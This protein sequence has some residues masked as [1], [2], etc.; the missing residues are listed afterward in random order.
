MGYGA[1]VHVASGIR[2]MGAIKPMIARLARQ[3]A[4][5]MNA[6]S[7]LKMFALAVLIRRL[8]FLTRVS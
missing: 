7:K 4:D 8:Q 5:L 3:S 2:C 6:L 1:M